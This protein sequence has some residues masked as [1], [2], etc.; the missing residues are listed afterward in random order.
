MSNNTDLPAP[1]ALVTGATSG[2]GREAARTLA[3]DG[4]SVLVH[5]RDAARGRG[6][7]G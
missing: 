1:V 7:G 6:S 3:T 5:G 4:F 2:I